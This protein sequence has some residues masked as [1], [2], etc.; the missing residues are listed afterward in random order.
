MPRADA[1]AARFGTAY[2][3]QYRRPYAG[4]VGGSLDPRRYRRLRRRRRSVFVRITANVRAFTRALQQVGVPFAQAAA[5]MVAMVAVGD[6]L[7]VEDARRVL[8]QAGLEDR[9]DE[10]WPEVERLHRESV[11]TLPESAQQVASAVILAG[12][13]CPR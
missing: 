12:L 4:R 1:R 8:W 7:A 13:S 6:A 9:I 10:L 2:T 11:L 3:P 5:A